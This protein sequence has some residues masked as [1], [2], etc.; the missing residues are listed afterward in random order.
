MLVGK[1]NELLAKQYF[2]ACYSPNH[3]IV[4]NNPTSCL[5][6]HDF[7]TYSSD[8]THLI[9]KIVDLPSVRG[10]QRSLHQT[11]VTTTIAE[12]SH[13]RVI[14]RHPLSIAENERQLPRVNR[15]I[16]AQLRSGWA[17]ILNSYRARGIPRTLACYPSCNQASHD[18][19]H[20]F[21]C[22]AKPT[23]LRSIDLWLKVYQA[24]GLPTT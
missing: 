24:E 22:A 15:T 16:Q 18:T 14:K 8:I 20:L 10:A 9:P 5:I 6:R 7:I 17:N 21:S 2:I 12:L 13:N 4:M 19:V 23:I 1:H 3:H 11:T